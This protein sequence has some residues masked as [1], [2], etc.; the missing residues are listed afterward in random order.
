MGIIFVAGIHGVGKTSVCQEV[1]KVLP[2]QYHTAS[3]LIREEKAAAIASNSK[4]V[5]DVEGNQLLL[6]QA[7]R[8]V[9]AAHG[10]ILLDGHFTLRNQLGNIELV[11]V[12]VFAN[13]GIT[14]IAVYKDEPE[15][16]A[17]RINQRDG[18]A[19]SIEDIGNHQAEEIAHSRLV[20]SALNI[21]FVEL[22]AF[23]AAGLVSYCEVWLS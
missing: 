6:I 16:I 1:T 19:Y 17:Q 2:I 3:Q 9:A 11:D 7:V 4:L 15:I 10:R 13:L 18:M 12:S 20:S 23:D 21:P 8:R 22:Q 14:G 5:A